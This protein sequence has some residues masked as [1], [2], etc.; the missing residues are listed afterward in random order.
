MELRQPSIQQIDGAFYWIAGPE[1]IFILN[2]K[3]NN[4]DDRYA[5]KLGPEEILCLPVDI[6]YVGEDTPR[7]LDD[8]EEAFAKLVKIIENMNLM[9]DKE[10]VSF[11]LGRGGGDHFYVFTFL[12]VAKLN[13]N[14]KFNY[15]LS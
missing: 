2:H 13:S 10:F 12:H 14:L 7:Y 6:V 4:N 3:R 11:P 5:R 9:Q 15:N 1:E 8:E